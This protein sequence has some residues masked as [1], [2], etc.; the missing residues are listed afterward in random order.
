MQL[1]LRLPPEHAA[2][3]LAGLVQVN[4]WQI[5]QADLAGETPVLDGLLAGAAAR[6][7]G[8]TPE[9][10]L[11]PQE[12]I[13]YAPLDPQEHWK[14]W[15][16]VRRDRK[17]DCEDLAPAVSAEL[18]ASGVP[19]RPVAYEA[20]PGVWHVVVQYRRKDGTWVYADPSL[21]GGMEGGA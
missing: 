18:L 8:L 13:H 16:A 4:L 15:A 12:A 1:V 2:G 10:P 14:D 17:A 7:V 21:L 11:W 3:V 19:A 20:L 6:R 9:S 5:H